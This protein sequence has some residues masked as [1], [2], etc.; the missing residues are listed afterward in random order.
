MYYYFCNLL[1][2]IMRFFKFVVSFVLLFCLLSSHTYARRRNVLNMRYFQN[3]NR[4]ISSQMFRITWGT[5]KNEINPYVNNIRTVSPYIIPEMKVDSIGR[6]GILP[7]GYEKRL[8]IYKEG[9]LDLININIEADNFDMSDNG[10]LFMANTRGVSNLRFK[11]MRYLREQTMGRYIAGD[12]KDKMIRVIDRFLV[13]N[14][15]VRSNQYVYNFK[16]DVLKTSNDITPSLT[17]ISRR[18]VV[19]FSWD[20]LEL[21]DET[22]NINAL[23]KMKKCKLITTIFGRIKNSISVTQAFEVSAQKIAGTMQKELNNKKVKQ[24]S[25]APIGSGEIYDLSGKKVAG[26][27]LLSYGKSF[28]FERRGHQFFYDNKK[29][30]GAYGETLTEI[31]MNLKPISKKIKMKNPGLSSQIRVAVNPLFKSLYSKLMIFGLKKLGARKNM[32]MFRIK[33][34]GFLLWYCHVVGVD[35]KNNLFLLATFLDKDR[36]EESMILVVDQKRKLINKI[37][38]KKNTLFQPGNLIKHTVDIDGKGNVYQMV[39][40][41]T[42]IS[43]YKYL[44]K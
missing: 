40:D 16:Y 11:A 1:G 21:V 9:Q 38:L 42:G 39:F 23:N 32:V 33:K 41:E 35:H 25:S 4:Y 37:Q 22:V 28:Y 3:R 18:N 14:N 31:N 43:V 34:K 30:K 44:K 7:V 15:S 2:G 24:I 36:N 10:Y 17:C 5:N 27:N 19:Y 6:I 13:N 20:G 8:F 26:F 12:K 29:L